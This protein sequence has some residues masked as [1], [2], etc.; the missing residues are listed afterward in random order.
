[1][2]GD[3]TPVPLINLGEGDSLGISPDGKWI[4]YESAE[5]GQL[6]VCVQPYPGPGGKWQVS[7][8]GGYRP[9]WSPKGNEIY[10]RWGDAM[11][12]GRALPND[13]AR[14]SKRAGVATGG[15]GLDQRTEEMRVLAGH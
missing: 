8:G 13:E 4:A 14:G 5:T 11:M 10:F 9:H 3:A 2:T 12:A 1:M 15:V 7:N 6:E